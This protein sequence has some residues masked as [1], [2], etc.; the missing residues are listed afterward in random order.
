MGREEGVVLSQVT[1]VSHLCCSQGGVQRTAALSSA[2]KV[3]GTLF[4]GQTGSSATVVSKQA[5]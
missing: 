3:Q 2:V 5:A 1:L 4:S